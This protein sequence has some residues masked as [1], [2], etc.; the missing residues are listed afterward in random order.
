[1]VVD[2]KTLGPT[3]VY[4]EDTMPIRGDLMEQYVEK[5]NGIHI[6]DLA[7]NRFVTEVAG[8]DSKVRDLP[9]TMTN[10]IRYMGVNDDTHRD[11]ILI[12]GVERVAALDSPHRTQVSERMQVKPRKGKID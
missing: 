6:P 4:F 3:G 10:D 9:C 11:I 1:L 5:K 7:G 2:D 8:D 12:K